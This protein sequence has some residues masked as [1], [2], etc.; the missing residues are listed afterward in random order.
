GK[1][2][3]QTSLISNFCKE[4]RD[5]H[6]KDYL[7]TLI[8]IYFKDESQQKTGKTDKFGIGYDCPRDRVLLYFALQATQLSVL[9]AKWLLK[10]DENEEHSKIAIN[11]HGGWHHAFRYNY[12]ILN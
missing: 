5:F 11:F 10:N 2:F 4:I 7:E 9:A 1:Y 8:Q 12:D 3:S 6:S